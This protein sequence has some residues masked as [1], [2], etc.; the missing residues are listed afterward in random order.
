MSGNQHTESLKIMDI[1][2]DTFR[3]ILNTHMKVTID[4]KPL[5]EDEIETIKKNGEI[6]ENIDEVIWYL[7][8]S[9][10]EIVI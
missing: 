9:G 7:H 8:A 10:K 6:I 1:L 5:T 2:G 3:K 4:Y